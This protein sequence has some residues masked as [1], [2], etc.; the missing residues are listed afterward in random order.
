[1]EF[2][3]SKS[4]AYRRHKADER[5]HAHI[6]PMTF[7][8]AIDLVRDTFARRPILPPLPDP[9][10]EPSLPPTVPDAGTELQIAFLV[11]MP[12]PRPP[13]DSHIVDAELGEYVIGT[14]RTCM[15]AETTI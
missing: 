10:D 7:E 8:H 14:V 5:L 2:E 9:P 1:M 15:K 4:E 12:S 11:A 13:V 6:Q 3:L